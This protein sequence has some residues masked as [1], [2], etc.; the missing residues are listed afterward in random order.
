MSNH[1]VYTYKKAKGISRHIK[2]K[3]TNHRPFQPPLGVDI[4]QRTFHPD[5]GVFAMQQFHVVGHDRALLF[6]RKPIVE[7][8]L[9]IKDRNTFLF[10]DVD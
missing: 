3:P 2:L 8:T 1:S 7:N 6:P 10:L 9:Q 5:L 4:P